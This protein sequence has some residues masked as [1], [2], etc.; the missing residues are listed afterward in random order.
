[1]IVEESLNKA[2]STKIKI[3]SKKSVNF[4]IFIICFLISL[5]LWL[6][7]NLNNIYSY[8]YSINLN[9]V[10]NDKNIMSLNTNN[11]NI[12]LQLEISGW[13]LIGLKLKPVE[14]I[15]VNIINPSKKSIYLRNY[16][17]TLQSSF[18]RNI[19]IVDIAP[20][21]IQLDYETKIKKK[22]KLEFEYRINLKEGYELT[23]FP[24][25]S[26]DSIFLEG[27][28]RELKNLKTLS[29]I[30]N[31]KGK[32]QNNIDYEID[33]NSYFKSEVKAIPDK[34][35]VKIPVDKLTEINLTKEIKIF[36]LPKDK[37]LEIYPSFVELSAQVP[38]KNYR[39]LDTSQFVVGVDASKIST[40]DRL[41]KLKV[42]I[43]KCPDFTY[44]QKTKT[45]FV[46][47]IIEE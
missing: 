30:V 31:P 33:I 11:K 47:Y 16:L 6:V 5:I 20:D 22:V 3:I 44:N 12:N 17:N 46:D 43:M 14:E 13:N 4:K 40:E 41:K 36:N 37:K 42:E 10:T 38:I 21:V 27:P 15:E 7:I 8:S 35:N 2:D 32:I 18:S 24:I 25:P 9:C 26:L 19:K 29:L 45:E 39:L 28:S 23:E 1:M 34:V